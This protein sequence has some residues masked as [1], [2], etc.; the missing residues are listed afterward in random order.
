MLTPVESLGPM[1]RQ[2]RNYPFKLLAEKVET[3]EAF[4]QCLDLGF[5]YF[6][7]YYFAKPA[8]IEKQ[9]IEGTATSLLRLLHL[10]MGDAEVDQIEACLRHCP[11]LTY[12]LLLLVNSLAMGA[13]TKISSVRHAIAMLGRRQLKRWVQLAL[14][15]TE[16]SRG[17][18]NPMVD[19]AAVRC[20]LMEQLARC[21][22]TLKHEAEVA[23]QAFLVGILSLLEWIY[24]VSM[25]EV[26]AALSLSDNVSAALLNREGV[27]GE[28]LSC[29]EAMEQMDF[30]GGWPKLEAMGF[31][32]SQV[33]EAQCKAFMWKAE[34]T[35]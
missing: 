24:A 9:R 20:G 23:D 13:R 8:V 28:L 4:N 2:L 19:M 17:L 15:V 32:H 33:L 6:Q 5:D 27:M 29:V 16:D 30:K 35:A 14:F 3:R 18:E 12:S 22:S 10:L 26:V 31:V 21:H 11:G 7:G 1:I 25:E 34:M